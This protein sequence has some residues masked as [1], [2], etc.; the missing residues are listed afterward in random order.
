MTTYSFFNSR[1]FSI[2]HLSML[3]GAVPALHAATSIPAN[4]SIG[5]NSI[6]QSSLRQDLKYLTSNP[7]KGRLALQPGDEMATQWIVTAFKQAGLK[8]VTDSGYLQAVPLIEYTP[9]REQSYVQLQRDD[10]STQWKKPEIF[11]EF[12][13]PVDL[14]SDVVFA[15]Y[16]ITAPDLNYDDYQHVNVVGKI[17]LIFEHEPQ[18]T[19]SASVFNGTGNTPYATTRIK[20]LNAQGHGAVAVLIAPE[21][22]RKHPSNQERYAH[23]GGSASRK[24]PLPSMV[25]ENDELHIPVVILSDAVA[26][27]IAGTTVNLSV[28]QSAI[29]HDLAPHSQ[30][31]P[32][33]HISIHD[34]NHS[35]RTATTYNVVGLLEGSDPNLKRDTIIISAH[36]DHDGQSGKQIW[37]GA[38]D[39]ASGTAGVVA[40]A[41]AISSNTASLTGTKPK[42]S[43]LFV[44]FAAEERGL[45]GAFYM[46]AHPLRPLQSTRAMINFDMIG[47]NEADSPQTSGL[48]DIPADTTNRLNLIGSHY[49]PDYERVVQTQNNYV[50]L[51][52]DD[53]FNTEYA[54]NTFFRS[55]QFPFVLQGIPAFWWFT[56]FHP[57]YHHTT[58][59]AERINYVKMQKILRLAYLTAYA[60]SDASSPPVFVKTPRA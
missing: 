14:T 15:G 7:L 54:L 17:V 59:T 36:H 28:L 13:K 47:R 19:N 26:K 8:P 4:L 50:G 57:D 33:A 38:D 1:L 11:T 48:I 12:F 2:L 41:K 46:T 21:P 30:A 37:H 10:H 56:G 44:V 32:D 5:W 53:R 60:F 58:D 39:N 43:I 24:V 3:L 20:A 45:L 40:L 18:E 31:I 23:I 35:Q 6:K 16:G 27:E 55:D 29:D 51:Q 25:L 34:R 52:L 49:S 22:N 9:D 42:R